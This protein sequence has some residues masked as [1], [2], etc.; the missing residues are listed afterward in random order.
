LVMP[1]P[2]DALAG[3]LVG[4]LERPTAIIAT[5]KNASSTPIA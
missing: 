2:L 5:A 1:L 3:W 4:R